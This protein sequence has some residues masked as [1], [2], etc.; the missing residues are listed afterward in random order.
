MITFSVMVVVLSSRS[1]MIP[2]TSGLMDSIFT[3]GLCESERLLRAA[4]RSGSHSVRKEPDIYLLDT[5]D[6]SYTVLCNL[7]CEKIVALAR[8]NLIGF[9]P[10]VASMLMGRFGVISPFCAFA[11]ANRSI[12]AHLGGIARDC[13]ENLPLSRSSAVLMATLTEIS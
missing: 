6:L 12:V 10:F 13:K 1:S 11:A 5:V 9:F 8:Y 7:R 2:S 4:G 3:P